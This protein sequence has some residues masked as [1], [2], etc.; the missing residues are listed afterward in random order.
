MKPNRLFALIPLALV[1]A[2]A[3]AI[4]SAQP[5]PKAA[6]A[7]LSPPVI[8]ELFT[9]L[10]CG[11]TPTNR[12]TVQQL[13]CA[14]RDI[15]STDKLIDAVSRTVFQRLGDDRARRRFVTAARAWLAYRNADCASRSDVFEGGSQAPVLDAQCTAARS[16]T[17]LA[18]LRTFAGDLP[19]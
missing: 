16:K 11:G 15:V 4:A 19:H 17:R 18:D 14:E 10:P 12:T 9:P 3:T 7:K 8:H 2:A 5:S 1:A 6:A 13:G